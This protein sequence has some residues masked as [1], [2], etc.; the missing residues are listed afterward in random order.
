MTV[1]VVIGTILVA[2]TMIITSFLVVTEPARMADFEAGYQGRSIEAG[3]A[4]FNSTCFTCHGINGEG[5]PGR[6]PALK[7]KDL[8]DDTGPKGETVTPAR[9]TEIK[10]PGSVRDYIKAAVAGGRPRAS[11]QFS[12]YP[13]RMPTWSQEFGGP[14]RPDQVENVVDFVMNWQADVEKLPD[15]TATPNPNAVGT[16]LDI[17]LPTGDPVQGEKLFKGQ[18]NGLYSC[19]ACHSLN[20]GEQ[21]VGPSLDGIA[22]RAAARKEGYSAEKYIHE[23]IVLPSAHIVEGF[24]SPSAMPIVFAGQMTKQE[25]AD[26]LAFLLTKK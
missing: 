6:G 18:V 10:W 3:A 9:L 7:A 24:T 20:P 21:I 23:S 1:R 11:V 4:I 12:I 13:E 17:E 8:L 19:Y 16:D 22:T 14:L 2:V 26:I 5:V 15:A 25:L